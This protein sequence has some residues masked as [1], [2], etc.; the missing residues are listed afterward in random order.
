MIS[1]PRSDQGFQW[2]RLARP[3]VYLLGIA[4][5]AAVFTALAFGTA[6]GEAI[7][8]SRIPTTPPN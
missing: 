4:V 6:K 7:E 1:P 5:P 3:A 2:A 8:I